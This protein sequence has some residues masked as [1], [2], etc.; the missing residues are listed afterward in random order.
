MQPLVEAI[1]VHDRIMRERLKLGFMSLVAVYAPTEMCETEE[2]EMF[3][4]QLDSVFDQCPS[5]DIFNVL[6]EFNAT[7]DTERAGY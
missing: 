4:A 2:K 1:S 3:Y 7:T 6:S 5:Q